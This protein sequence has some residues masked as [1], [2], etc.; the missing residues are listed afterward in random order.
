MLLAF[1]DAPVI[2]GLFIA[3]IPLAI[4]PTWFLWRALERAGLAGPL[5]LL[6]MVPFGALV[7]LGILAFADWPALQ[8]SGG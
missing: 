2:L 6:Y 4:V 5:A 7:V 1:I 8:K 3:L